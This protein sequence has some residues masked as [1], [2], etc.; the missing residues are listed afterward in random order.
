MELKQRETFTYKQIKDY[1]K[2]PLCYHI[3]HVEKK[4]VDTSYYK[5]HRRIASDEAM[6]SAITYYYFRLLE[7]KPP[8]LKE[9]YNKY[10]KELAKRI[11][12]PVG[13]DSLLNNITDDQTR[14]V[15]RNGYKWMR[16]FYEWNATTPQAI[17][18]VKHPFQLMYDEIVVEDYFPLIREIQDEEGKRLVELVV[19]GQTSKN[20]PKASTIDPSDT[21]VL[22]KGFQEVF[23]VNPDKFTIYSVERAKTYEVYRN[24]SDL[25]RLET[26][27]LGFYQSQKHVEPYQKLGAHPYHGKFKQYCDTYYD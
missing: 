10:Y 23:G 18:A 1:M 3:E 17:I 26:S 9:L 15:T 12:L 14:S 19:F 8:A 16:Q 20:S 5:E 7:N 6:L 22:L 2:C 24:E 13:R 27:F 11:D 4:E 21:T 25:K